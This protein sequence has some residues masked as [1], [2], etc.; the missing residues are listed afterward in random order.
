[1]MLKHLCVP[2]LACYYPLK[3][4]KGRKEKFA[5][6]MVYCTFLD[7]ES[8]KGI[9]SPILGILELPD[10]LIRPSI[11]HFIPLSKNGIAQA[12][13]FDKVLRSPGNTTQIE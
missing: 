7:I 9:K 4:K 1:M 13:R 12:I 10:D 11:S 5:R 3:S 8:I 2:G 6:G